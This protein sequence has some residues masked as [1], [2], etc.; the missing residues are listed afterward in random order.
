MLRRYEGLFLFDSAVIRDW[1]TIE[2]EVKRLME[3]IGATLLVCV[4]FDERKLAFEI[5][6]RKRGTYVLTY[7]DA[8]MA[9]IGELERDA[10]LS[11]VILR[12]M[13]LRR[14]LSEEKLAQLKAH[15]PDVALVPAGDGRRG[16][17]RGRYD[18]GGGRHDDRDH[19][20][21][22]HDRGP[23]NDAAPSRE[24]E[25]GPAVGELDEA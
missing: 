12:A 20:G 15:Q 18:D 11:E 4:K 25:E 14:D 7:F 13:V 6:R 10:Q 22:R 3:R 16:D 17:D 1:P 5:R 21:G 9:K 2:A 19:R 8:P 24:F 23:D